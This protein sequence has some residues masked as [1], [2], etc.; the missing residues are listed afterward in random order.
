[1][2]KI[3]RASV[4][5]LVLACSAQAGEMQNGVPQPPPP[6]PGEIVLEE[7]TAVTAEE[8]MSN[9]LADT[10]TAAALSVLDDVLALL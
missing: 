2:L 10:L 4:F 5:V 9:D 7:T 1:M 6:P 8:D 3:I